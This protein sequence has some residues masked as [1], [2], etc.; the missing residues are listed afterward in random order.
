MQLS[1]KQEL[2]LAHSLLQGGLWLQ[3]AERSSQQLRQPIMKYIHEADLVAKKW[4]CWESADQ[5]LGLNE[6]KNSS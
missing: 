6:E 4:R 5:Q 2:Q 1:W 3:P